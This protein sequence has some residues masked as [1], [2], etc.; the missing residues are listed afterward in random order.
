MVQDPGVLNDIYP[1]I[2]EGGMS[3]VHFITTGATARWF[4]EAEKLAG[5]IR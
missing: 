1:G 5:H 3:T 2:G 4:D